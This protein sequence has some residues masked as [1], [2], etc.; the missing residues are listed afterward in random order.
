[1]VQFSGHLLYK[2]LEVYRLRAVIL[3]VNSLRHA[4]TEKLF[5]TKR[6]K[7][8]AFLQKLMKQFKILRRF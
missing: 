6:L 2:V 4:G 3:T 5:K 8:T 1:M 7:R